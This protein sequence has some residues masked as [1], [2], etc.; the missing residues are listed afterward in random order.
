MTTTLG[1]LYGSADSTPI[2]N[3]LLQSADHAGGEDYVLETKVDVSQL[4]GGYAQGGLIVYNGDDD[5]VKFDPIS[6]QDQTASTGSSCAR[7]SAERS[8]SR[9]RRSTI[10][11]EH[12]GRVAAADQD[13]HHLR[14]RVL[15]DGRTWAAL[16]ATV[17][18]TKAP[19]KFGIFQLGVQ[20]AGR[21]VTFDYLKVNGSTG[22]PPSDENHAPE[23]TS[24]TAT[25]TSGFA[26]LPVAF[27]ASAT[28]A[29]EDDLTYRW[30]FG[31][32]ATSTAQNP[33][34]TYAAAGSY[35]RR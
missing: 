32:G 33:S 17:P 11:G 10:P 30:E 25:P 12:E 1:D 22:C 21:V 24:A 8:R 13:R 19:A 29:D 3:I 2:K 9:S 15:L 18:N 20:I 28:D 31:D 26:P 7:R 23:I 27:A 4:N 6:D 5:Y 16:S 14:G 35:A 34:H